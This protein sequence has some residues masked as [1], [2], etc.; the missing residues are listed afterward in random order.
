MI[1]AGFIY[2]IGLSIITIGAILLV[3][4][5]IY[6]K[7]MNKA[8][9]GKGTPG[10]FEPG[11]LIKIVVTTGAVIMM[12]VGLNKVTTIQDNLL[13][14]RNEISQLQQ[15]IWN[16]QNNI[17]SLRQDLEDY[18]QEQNIV[19]TFEYSVISIED[20]GDLGY[21]IN[22]QLLEIG[23]ED[24]IKLV[25]DD[26]INENQIILSSSSLNYSTN[27]ILSNNTEYDFY[28]LIEGDSLIQQD[29]GT[30][31]VDSSFNSRFDTNMSYVFLS[32]EEKYY[33]DVDLV[34]YFVGSADV[35]LA[36]VTIS[37]YIND[38]NVN[39]ITMTEPTYAE[40]DYE[41]FTYRTKIDATD[42]DTVLIVIDI[43][44][45]YGNTF[46]RTVDDTITP[47]F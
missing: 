13:N 40:S 47:D 42:E 2:V 7:N 16:L 19:Q 10:L 4:K 44:D 6:K 9:T 46:T 23:A 41:A 1:V 36:E 35:K 15:T 43:L 28:V 34:N 12:I 31:E 18:Q 30:I 39:S 25:Y 5:Y 8:L 29:L 33:I 17:S 32:D 45:N 3:Y 26:G 37:V 11:Q 22:F 14:T 21:M 27:L 38:L 24:I 20:N